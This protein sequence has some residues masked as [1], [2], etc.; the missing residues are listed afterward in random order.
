MTNDKHD[1][2]NRFIDFFMKF[3]PLS[4]T[5]IDTCARIQLK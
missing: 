2:L 4:S 5:N 3:F 1:K